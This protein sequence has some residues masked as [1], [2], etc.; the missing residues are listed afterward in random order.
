MEEEKVV[1]AKVAW[2]H[3]LSNILGSFFINRWR[4]SGKSTH[5]PMPRQHL[6]GRNWRQ[7]GGM[8]GC[9]EFIG[10]IIL[11]I[12][13]SLLHWID[14][15]PFLLNSL[16]LDWLNDWCLVLGNKHDQL[17]TTVRERRRGGERQAD[18]G[19][20]FRAWGGGKR[21]GIVCCSRRR[22]IFPLCSELWHSSQWSPPART[23][24]YEVE[25]I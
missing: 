6:I 1:L 18:R 14:L 21:R 2:S 25:I 10:H 24:T 5:P 20:G 4:G 12:C 23:R 22:Q 17:S 15:K 3:I 16:H 11:L 19:G 9:H 13:R 7:S 8:S